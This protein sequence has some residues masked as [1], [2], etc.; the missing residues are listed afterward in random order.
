V[1]RRRG[2]LAAPSQL[3]E[4]QLHVAGAPRGELKDSLAERAEAVSRLYEDDRGAAL[5]PQRLAQSG[6]PA[7]EQD[8]ARGRHR[9]VC[10][11]LGHPDRAENAS[12]LLRGL[13]E[14]PDRESFQLD[15]QR[16]IQAEQLD[17]EELQV[18]TARFACDMSKTLGR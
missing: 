13:L 5:S 6:V 8:W 12:A 1:E 15:E 4:Q 2:N 18:I 14:L 17:V 9:R 3:L 16:P 7:E 11:R 10:E